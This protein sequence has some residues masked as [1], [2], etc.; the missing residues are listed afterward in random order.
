MSKYQCIKYVELA[1][2]SLDNG[3]PG[4]K[5]FSYP[6]EY[7]LKLIELSETDLFYHRLDLDSHNNVGFICENTYFPINKINFDKYFSKVEAHR[8]LHIKRFKIDSD[9]SNEIESFISN[10]DKDD[11]KYVK[12]SDNY[13][14]IY[15]TKYL[16]SDQ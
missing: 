4:R 16:E 1:G 5:V 14:D 13:A 11:I 15:Y 3:K 6:D 7:D 2:Y 9:N 10:K 8:N 12:Y